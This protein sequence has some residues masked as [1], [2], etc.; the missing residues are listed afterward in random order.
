MNDEQLATLP[1]SVREWDE[2]VNSDTPEVFWDR[3]SNMRSKIGTGLYKPGEDAGSEDWGKF[4]DKAMELAGDRLIP[5]P[6]LEDEA[7]RNAF[8]K[9]LG[10]P[11]DAAGYTFDEIEGMPNT[12]DERKTVISELA[13]KANL[14]ASQLKT[15]ETGL[16][17]TTHAANTAAIDTLNEGLADL[18]QDWGLATEERIH[19]ARKV[20]EIFFPHID[21]DAV[22]SS[23]ELKSF[24]SLSKQLGKV[25]GEFKEQGD[26]HYTGPSPADAAAKI[27]EIRNN[28]EH[29][30][31]NPTAP[32]HQDAKKQMRKL[33][34]AK[35]GEVPE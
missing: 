27:A 21:K 18:K 35:N 10:R 2:A 26:Q 28:K 1:E 34:L 19:E 4:T 30:Y 20:A 17:E 15:L 32:G 9:S 7:Q 16:R 22:L 12:T 25:S 11:D 8:Y 3:M 23:A 33:Y 29:P 6:D 13:F 5:R 14:S 24:Y 31:N